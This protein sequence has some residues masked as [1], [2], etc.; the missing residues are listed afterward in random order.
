MSNIAIDA[1]TIRN[2]T[3]STETAGSVASITSAHRLK[4]RNARSGKT[5]GKFE[6]LSR[7]L[8]F[9]RPCPYLDYHQ[10]ILKLELEQKLEIPLYKPKTQNGK[11]VRNRSP[12]TDD[13]YYDEDDDEDIGQA[14]MGQNN[15]NRSHT[16]SGSRVQLGVFK[17]E[18]KPKIKHPIV[19]CEG[20]YTQHEI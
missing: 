11:S 1:Q 7:G 17:K 4:L 5:D 14:K 16:G 10:N 18:K 3:F 20:M 19:E 9:Q 6:E 15:S 8:L 12:S 13:D 2:R